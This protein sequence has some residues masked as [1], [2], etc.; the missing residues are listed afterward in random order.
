VSWRLSREQTAL[1]I[2]LGMVAVPRVLLWGEVPA[3]V[4]GDEMGFFAT[5]IAEFAH[6]SPPW[7][8]G[9]NSLPA[10]HFWLMGLADALLGRDVWSARLVTALFGA[11]QALAVVAASF[12]LAGGSGALTAAAVL[13]LPLELHFERLNM[14]NVWTTATWSCA[15]ALAVLAPWRAW[16]SCLIGVLLA[17]GW[18]GYQSSRLVPL[19]AALPLL[20]LLVRASRSQRLQIA[21]GLASFALTMGPLLY[22]FWLTP[23]VIAGRATYTSWTAAGIDAAGVTSH[24][25]ATLSAI[26]GFAYDNSAFFP[27]QMPL[28]SSLVMVLAALGLVMGRPWPLALCL[29]AWI[30]WVAVG[31]FVRNIPVYSCVLI[32]AV[33][34]VAIAAGLSARLLGV[35]APLLAMVAVGPVTVRYFGDARDVPPSLRPA[36]AYYHA[37]RS[38]P[39][40][41][42]LLLAG[43]FGCGHGFS[44]LHRRCIDLEEPLAHPPPGAYAIATDATLA[45]VASVA[46]ERQRVERFD[47]PLVVIRP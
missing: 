38:V 23:Q 43:T 24:L 7:S 6:R 39:V 16:S 40:D 47:I 30:G 21:L 35:V 34:A 46:G 9:P 32:C 19:I 10:A 8:F 5:G 11:A 25:Q 44:Q 33:P 37:V 20:I 4:D 3:V 1:L 15:F 31:N 41:A 45:L 29:A 42:P 28:F 12:R 14:C 27:Y 2:A 17:A 18:Y 22:G 26:A 13:C 36:M